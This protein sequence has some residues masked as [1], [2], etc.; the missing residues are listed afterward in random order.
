MRKLI[1]FISANL[2]NPTMY[3]HQHKDWPHFTWD[4]NAVSKALAQARHQQGFLLGKMKSVGFNMREEAELLVL[5]QDVTKSSEIEGE[6]LDN[7]QVRSSIARRLG[8]DIGPLKAVDRH[9][10]GVVEM[11]LDASQRYDSKLTAARLFGWH[12]ALFPTGFSGMF[13]I[14]VGQWRT[15]PMQVVS[16]PMGREKVHFESPIAEKVAL[17]MEVFLQW[18]NDNEDIDLVLK[19]AIAHLWFVTIHPFDDGNGR[20]G[21]A[22]A[23][24][25]LALSE[26]SSHRFYSLSAQILKERKTYYKLLESTQKDDLDITEWL[27]WFLACM[28][29]AIDASD[30]ILASVLLKAKF[31][32]KY[33][34]TSFNSR[35]LKVLKRLL[36][37]FEG[38]MTSGKYGRMTTTSQDTAA[39]DLKDLAERGVLAKAEGGGRS[40][41]YLLAEIG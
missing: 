38:K 40:T 6:L 15:G 39:R 2:Y 12:A 8:I 35:Q 11:M 9:V 27:L 16:G 13:K 36:D 1:N 18:F 25:G 24:M 17:E 41:G 23:D 31:W 20:I 34:T 21:R 10:E 4:K 32:E 22:I 33:A 3:I 30:E 29:R 26:N 37:G 5:T 28:E 14:E 19:T 7:E